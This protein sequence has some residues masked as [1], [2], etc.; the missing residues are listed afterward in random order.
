MED[1]FKIIRSVVPKFEMDELK[2]SK[3]KTVKELAATTTEYLLKTFGTNVFQSRKLIRKAN[4]FCDL[5]DCIEQTDLK[6]AVLCVARLNEIGIDTVADI[7]F[8]DEQD[9]SNELYIRYSLATKLKNVALE[10]VE[11]YNKRT[12]HF[13]SLGD[14]IKKS[15]KCFQTRYRGYSLRTYLT[16]SDMSKI[17]ITKGFV[18]L[19]VENNQGDIDLSK[20]V[21]I[22]RRQVLLVGP[23]GSGKSELCRYLCQ[24]WA[25]GEIL[26]EY[27]LVLWCTLR[28]LRGEKL[29]ALGVAK[30]CLKKVGVPNDSI[31]CI[32]EFF[33]QL[34]VLYIFDSLDEGE[35]G[36]SEKTNHFMQEVCTG[37]FYPDVLVTS[38][39]HYTTLVRKIDKVTLQP[40]SSKERDEYVDK[41]FG[42]DEKNKAAV[43]QFINR[44]QKVQ[45]ICQNPLMLELICAVLPQKG[46]EETIPGVI[47]HLIA[48]TLREKK[49]LKIHDEE[50]KDAWIKVLTE[51]ASEGGG[52]FDKKKVRTVCKKWYAEKKLDTK[53][54]I[55]DMEMLGVLEKI[56]ENVFKFSYQIFREFF[57]TPQKTKGWFW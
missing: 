25:D 29:T 36:A 23:P 47:R 12:D 20:V 14:A 15:V 1:L 48:R 6:G 2:R 32:I 51:L 5:N 56:D 43:N 9:L 50:Y 46:E 33:K 45:E 55:D 34:K 7:A 41:Y 4:D 3:F 8:A 30:Y 13:I 28:E 38:R 39:A 40:F 53:G 31:Q 27:Q 42:K 52:N 19:R 49:R 35:N 21:C 22:E 26:Q 16:G 11:D 24:K 18:P 44:D 17:E 57:Y 54:C 37:Q 10:K